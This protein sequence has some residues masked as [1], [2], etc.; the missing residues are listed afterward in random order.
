[1]AAGAPRRVVG[2]ALALALAASAA[3]AWHA[4]GH[5][6]TAVDA[7]RA[8]PPEVPAFLRDAEAE[9]ARA[10]VEPDLWKLRLVPHL[11]GRESPDHHLDLERLPAGDVASR[12]PEHEA[13]LAAA[14]LAVGEVGTLAQ[15]IL[16]SVERLALGFAAHRRA[17][18]DAG[19]R[20]AVALYAGWLAHYAGD[21][22]QP[23]HTTIHHDGWALADGS[24][25]LEGSHR[26]VDALLERAEFAREAAVG[27]L[28]IEPFDD[29]AAA[30][31]AELAASH[32]QVDRVYAL[33]PALG[34]EAGYR[35]AAVAAFACERHRATVAF[36]ARLVLTAWR[37]SAAIELPDWSMEPPGE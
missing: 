25:P 30:V 22:E 6:R 33:L 2:A 17:P 34:D 23:L 37:E 19:A 31:R 9:V 3:P 10:A 4:E 32:A 7:L 26:R 14:G 20:G 21:L 28:A 15:A 18:H 35:R 8:L 11:A 5:R 1:L 13:R 36:V 24:S 16:E 12:R 29:L 27:G